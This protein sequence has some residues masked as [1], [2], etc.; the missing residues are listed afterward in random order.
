[1]VLVLI[2]RGFGLDRPG[3]VFILFNRMTG[4]GYIASLRLMED[5]VVIPTGIEPVLP[6]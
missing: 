2:K 4:Q 6:A 1:M 3:K 5:D